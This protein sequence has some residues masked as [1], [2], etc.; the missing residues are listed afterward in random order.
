VQEDDNVQPGNL[1]VREGLIEVTAATPALA[2]FSTNV[3]GVS[4]NLGTLSIDTLGS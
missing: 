2:T 1:L 4:S 3:V